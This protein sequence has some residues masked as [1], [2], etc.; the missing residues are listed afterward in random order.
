MDQLLHEEKRTSY[1][2]GGFKAGTIQCSDEE[3]TP[4]LAVARY[5]EVEKLVGRSLLLL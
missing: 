1:F 2:A 4:A 5:K 3:D